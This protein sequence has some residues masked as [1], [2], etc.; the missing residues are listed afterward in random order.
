MADETRILIVDDHPV[1]RLG[2]AQ[3][4]SEEPDLTVTADAETS[5]DAMKKLSEG[6]LDMTI[7]D[8]SLGSGSGLELIYV[9]L[10]AGDDVLDASGTAVDVEA[11]VYQCLVHSTIEVRLIESGFVSLFDVGN[12]ACCTDGNTAVDDLVEHA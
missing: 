4:I 8:L 5:T 12:F 10:G 1:V 11:G 7:V 3:L 2:I 9:D 6:G